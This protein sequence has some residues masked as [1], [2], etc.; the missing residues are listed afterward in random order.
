M[1]RVL[2][3]VRPPGGT[4]FQAEMNL[5]VRRRNVSNLRPVVVRV[6][7]LRDDPNSVIFD[8]IAE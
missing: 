6:K 3:E 7:Y 8:G 4:P 1:F 2:V 5:P